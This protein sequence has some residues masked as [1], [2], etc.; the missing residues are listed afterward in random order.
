MTFKTKSELD[1]AT[2][3]LMV[4]NTDGDIEA[5]DVN[6]YMD[7]IVDSIVNVQ[8]VSTI[9]TTPVTVDRDHSVLLVDA[10]TAGEAV[11]I[12]LPAAAGCTDWVKTIKKI[13]AG[14]NTVTIDGNASEEIEGETTQVLTAEFD[15]LTIICD[16]TAWWILASVITAP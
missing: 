12:N 8:R 9:I 10:A 16:G 5:D 13:D 11:T 14:A 6:T 7:N 2:T 3:A 15:Y 4:V 1:T